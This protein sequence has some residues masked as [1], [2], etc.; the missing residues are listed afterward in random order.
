MP[1][2]CPPKLV[3]FFGSFGWSWVASRAIGC[4]LS[5]V[6][7]AIWT[8][9][10]RGL[11]LRCK[12]AQLPEAF[13]VFWGVRPG[14]YLLCF[15]HLPSF[16]YDMRVIG[17]ILLPVNSLCSTS[18]LKLESSWNGPGEHWQ[19][20]CQSC[21]IWTLLPFLSFLGNHTLKRLGNLISSLTGLDP[22]NGLCITLKHI[23]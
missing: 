23:T 4:E 12:A 16:S 17:F 18:Y 10:S 2:R 8:K 9:G 11:L 13:P 19:Y 14:P 1:P 21:C 22:Q 15:R 3:D 6:P 5:S 7:A 20:S